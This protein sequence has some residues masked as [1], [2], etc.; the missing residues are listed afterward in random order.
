MRIIVLTVCI[1]LA[2]SVCAQF[3]L[4]LYKAYDRYREVTIKDRRFKHEDIMKLIDKLGGQFIVNQVG[5]S[6]EKRAL[7][8]VSF[9]DGPVNVLMWSQMHGNEPTAT[10]ALMDI[11]NFLEADDEFN[12]FRREIGSQLTLHF[13]PMLNPDGAARF[14]RRNVQGIDINRDALM[15]QTP[16]GQTLKR[17]RDSLNAD[18]GFNLHDQGRATSVNTRPATISVLAPAYN[19][20]REVNEKRGDAMQLISFMNSQIQTFIPDQV[21]RYWD[22]F[23]PRAFGDNI[24]KW[25]TR[26]ILIESGGYQG[27]RDKQQIRRINFIML[28]TAFKSMIS[29][30]YE[31]FPVD[32]YEDI[33][34]NGGIRLHDLIVRNLNFEGIQRDIAFRMNETDSDDYRDYYLAGSISDIGDLS[35]SYAYRTFDA[36]GLEVVKGKVYHEVLNKIEDF[37]TL[38]TNALL[39]DGYTDFIVEEGYDPFKN[40]YGVNIH[41]KAPADQRIDMGQNPSLVLRRNNS[42]EYLLINGAIISLNENEGWKQLFGPWTSDWAEAGNANWRRSDGVLTGSDSS[43]FVMTVD[44]FE[45]FHLKLE[46][47]SDSEVNSGVFVRC[48]DRDSISQA[49]CYEIN[50]WDEHPNQDYRTGAVVGIA[51]PLKKVSTTG[52]WSTYEIRATGNRIEAWVNGEKTADLTHDALSM[53]FI[54][55][56]V[57]SPGEIR[58]RNV[59]IKEL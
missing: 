40:G 48:G 28:L 44:Q 43:G 27:D 45:D 26:T 20:E 52:K 6:A 55:L 32:Q 49:T 9:G 34:N 31:D 24:Q 22:D 46:F 8:L 56:Q 13:L 1:G 35:T 37:K 19:Y 14:Q 57:V 21:G 39:K 18:W 2:G 5:E 41:K 16:E 54:A 7:K 3:N 50:I 53:G 36:S 10:M 33:P 12:P 38:N 25:G 17:V 11:F 29:G 15:L 51:K 23:E 59:R 42:A 4:D 30:A 47:L 58:F